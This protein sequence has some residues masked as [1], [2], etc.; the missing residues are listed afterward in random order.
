MKTIKQMAIM[1]RQLGK[2]L[3]DRIA[4]EYRDRI[5]IPNA[6]NGFFEKIKNVPIVIEP[7]V[8]P[9]HNGL[10]IRYNLCISTVLPNNPIKKTI[11]LKKDDTTHLSNIVSSIF[12]ILPQLPRLQPPLLLRPLRQRQPLLPVPLQSL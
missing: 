1:E 3:E 12:A 7:Q 9:S 11:S 8:L 6:G 5:V 10:D 2:L 4:E